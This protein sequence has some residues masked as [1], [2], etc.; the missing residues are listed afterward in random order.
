MYPLGGIL[1]GSLVAGYLVSLFCRLSLRRER[2]P[3]WFL[4][5]L[6]IGIGLVA[7]LAATFQKDLFQPSHW[8]SKVEGSCLLLISGVP[9]AVLAAAV[10]IPLLCFYHQK[11][12]Q[13]HPKP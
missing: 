11:Y 12:A 2:K 13:S 8:S 6:S 10:A 9:A 4:A 5:P 7:T 3:S 1:L